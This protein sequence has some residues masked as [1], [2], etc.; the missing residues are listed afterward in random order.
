MNS[1]MPDS[2]E[3]LKLFLF[4]VYVVMVAELILGLGET[5]WSNLLNLI[6]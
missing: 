3:Q 5:L 4:H 6:N 1:K 2:R